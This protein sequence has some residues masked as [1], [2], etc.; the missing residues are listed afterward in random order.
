MQK[1][2]YEYVHTFKEGLECRPQW[3]SV[4]VAQNRIDLDVLG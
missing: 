3:R 4:G 2:S 1:G